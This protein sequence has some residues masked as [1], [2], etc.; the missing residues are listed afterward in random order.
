MRTAK[1]HRRQGTCDGAE[2]AVPQSVKASGAMQ[3]Y[4]A[5]DEKSQRGGG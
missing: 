2:E 3:S 1:I 4:A 5:H